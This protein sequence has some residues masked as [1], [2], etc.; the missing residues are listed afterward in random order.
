MR[1]DV[2]KGPIIFAGYYV[3]LNKHLL[4]F[5]ILQNRARHFDNNLMTILPST[6]DFCAWLLNYIFY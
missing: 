5:K 3:A 4:L 2:Q 6:I 1:F